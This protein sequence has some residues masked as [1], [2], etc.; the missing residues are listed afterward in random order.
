MKWLKS[1]FR[2]WRRETYLV[3][4]DVGVLLF[5]FALPLGYPLIYTI[6]YNPETIEESPIVVVD[7]SRT[8][9]SRELVRAV[10]ATQALHV[11][12]YAANMQE[13]RQA[14][15]EKKCYA[16]LEVPADYARRIGNGETAVIPFYQD[17]SLLF[18]YR[19]ALLALTDVQMHEVTSITASRLADRGGILSTVVSGLPVDSN[20]GILGDSTQGF[21]SFIMPGVLVMILQQ[22]LL[23]GITM[24]A[25]T[26]RDRRRRN[27]TDTDP[28]ALN[29]GPVATLLGKTLCYVMIYFPMT[30]YA[31]T[32]VPYIF[33]LPHVGSFW[34]YMPF[35]LVM[36]LATSFL[37]QTVQIFV[38][39]REASMVLVVYTSVIVLF[40]SGLTWPRYAFNKFWMAISDLIPATWGVEGFI[41]INAN[42]ATISD[43]PRYYWALWI[44]TGVYFLTA[45]IINIATRPRRQTIPL[46]ADE[47]ESDKVS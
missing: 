34:D 42:A 22:S 26:S 14:W 10:D 16:V 25:G 4:S 5:F 43:F 6:I 44:L 32:V 47:P 2:V 8:A 17:M 30:F 21:A 12:G 41:R 29:E 27:G 13:A 39:E 45:L 28:L 36:L 7:N 37:G 11:V 18:R 33:S 35:I 9:E 24:L 23:L 38:R 46:K 3:F 15:C 19:Q 20:A 31:L 40:M 1:L